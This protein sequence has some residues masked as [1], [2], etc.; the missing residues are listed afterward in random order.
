MSYSDDLMARLIPPVTPPITEAD[1]R[2]A[3]HRTWTREWARRQ[4]FKN[5]IAHIPLRPEP[6][7][8]D[9]HLGETTGYWTE[10]L[11]RWQE[12]QARH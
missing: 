4:Q 2:C 7:L 8:R 12:A 1:Y 11:R 9:L 6:D 10:Y 5:A 3:D